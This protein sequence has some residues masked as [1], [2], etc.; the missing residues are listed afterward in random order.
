MKNE[1][2]INPKQPISE[3]LGCCRPSDDQSFASVPKKLFCVPLCQQLF[4]VSLRLQL[5][6]ILNVKR[7]PKARCAPKHCRAQQFGV[8]GEL[9]Q[10]ATE[11]ADA[12]TFAKDIE[13]DRKSTRLNS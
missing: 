8:L 1:K 12:A 13:R 6:L 3:F 5:A 9:I 2:M 10:G 7:V 4:L 11:C